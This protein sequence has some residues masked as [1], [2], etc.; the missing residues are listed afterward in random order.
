M[1]RYR[2]Q[3][4]KWSSYTVHGVGG[5]SSV[6]DVRL[7]K[8]TS[9]NMTEL[10]VKPDGDWHGYELRWDGNV[11]VSKHS[12]PNAKTF[13]ALANSGNWS[14]GGSWRGW[15]FGTPGAVFWLTRKSHQEWLVV[16]Q[17]G[18]ERYETNPFVEPTE[19]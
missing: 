18:F 6:N 5:V 1:K 14:G 19:I 4:Y 16:T 3:S 7:K 11:S 13:I 9:G 15:L 2:G 12:D 17:N 8:R 10:F